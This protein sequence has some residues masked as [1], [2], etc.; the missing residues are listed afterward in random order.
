MTYVT[1]ENLTDLAIER[2]G[3]IPDPRLRQIMT[4]LVKHLHGFIREVEPTPQEWAAGIDWLT[5][6]G[7]ICDAKRQEFIL[8][9][10]VLGVSML[11]DAINNRAPG[12][13]TPSTVEGPF[14]I[15][16]SPDLPDGANM[17]D[18][19]PGIP[20]FCTGKVTDTNGKPIAGAMLDMWQTD[21]EG[22]YEAQIPGA[23]GYMRGIFHTNPDGSYTVRT[24]APIGYTIPMDGPIGELMRKTHISHMRPAHIHFHIAAPGYKSLTTHLF[25]K[26]CDY[27]DTDVV[28]GVKE[29]L[30]VEFVK[31]PAGSKAPNGEIMNEPFYEV[32]YDFKL[33]KAA[34]AQKAA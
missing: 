2:W 19:A 27:I 25:Q 8:A 12:S 17:A 18:G 26:G 14:H 10:D 30:I 5:R 1:E 11:V 6:V 29:P 31:K 4:S 24:V 32:K 21:G 28:F 20:T 22:L 9:S 23:E 33:A 3:N 7:Q 34:Q 15:P 13:A 16:D